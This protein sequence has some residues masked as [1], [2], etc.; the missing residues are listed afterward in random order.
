VAIE[1]NRRYRTPRLGCSAPRW[2]RQGIGQI[3][4][5]DALNSYTAR[6]QHDVREAKNGNDASRP[7]LIGNIRRK[8]GTKAE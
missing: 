3:S 4:L 7:I 1:N 6:A 8:P 2:S 5:A